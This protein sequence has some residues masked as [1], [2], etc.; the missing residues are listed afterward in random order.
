M[1]CCTTRIPATGESL[2][3]RLSARLYRTHLGD[4]TSVHITLHNLQ[5]VADTLAL[6]AR[7]A[8]SGEAFV[9][10]DEIDPLLAS[11]Q[12]HG[13]ANATA[14]ELV[15]LALRIRRER[16][17]SKTARLKA[18]T[19]LCQKIAAADD[20]IQLDTP[21]GLQTIRAVI[22]EE[23]ERVGMSS[24]LHH[25][26]FDAGS[27]KEIAAGEIHAGITAAN[28]N[29]WSAA[30][31]RGNRGFPASAVSDGIRSTQ[32]AGETANT[33][34]LPFKPDQISK[35]FALT[36]AAP[37]QTALYWLPLLMLMTGARPN[38]LA[39]LRTDDLHMRF[40]GRPHLNVLCL[41]RRQR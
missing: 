22:R 32:G 31:L 16:R 20:Q 6:P 7:F 27:L 5:R 35:L 12:P 1:P 28:R 9:D 13:A 24:I 37:S 17:W 18:P 15:Q 23:I 34:R 4:T 14:V 39:R 29:R 33:K 36:S 3:W 41:A 21:R 25:V 26:P 8:P 40:N 38:E 2:A 10:V 19:A 30:P 11:G